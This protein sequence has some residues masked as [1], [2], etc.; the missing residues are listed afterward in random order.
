MLRKL[1]YL[2]IIL[3]LGASLLLSQ[4]S[5]V[6]T[7]IPTTKH[8]VVSHAPSNQI[9]EIYLFVEGRVTTIID[10]DTIKVE[11]KDGKLYLIR[12]QGID[13][14]ELRQD[15]GEKSK[16]KLS[17]LIKGKDV[18]VIIRKKDSLGNFIGTVYFDGQDINL[19]QIET[20]SVWHYKHNGYEQRKEYQKFYER[21]EQTARAEKRGLWEDKNPIM[22]SN[23]R[24]DNQ[25]KEDDKRESNEQS[26]EIISTNSDTNSNKE[27]VTPTPATNSNKSTGRTYIRGTRGGCYYINS[28]G[29]KTYVERSLCN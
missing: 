10:G 14:P 27:V 1:F 22:P 28:K 9:D 11:A 8:K 15:Y 7:S 26:T 12:M 17:D 23:F 21:A 18:T 5:T 4:T 29:N 3:C 2:V 24:G 25:I 16:K 19:K 20:G 13:A 6:T